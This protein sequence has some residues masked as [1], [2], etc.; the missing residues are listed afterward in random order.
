MRNEPTRV[1]E[2]FR[3]MVM[4]V[5]GAPFWL[6]Y[7]IHACFTRNL[8]VGLIFYSVNQGAHAPMDTCLFGRVMM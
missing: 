6:A 3:M 7:P 8:A 2:Q 1:H 5:V 4:V